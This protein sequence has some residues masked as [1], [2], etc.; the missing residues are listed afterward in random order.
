MVRQFHRP[1]RLDPE[2]T[3]QIEGSTDTAVAS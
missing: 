1:A 3:E 2:A